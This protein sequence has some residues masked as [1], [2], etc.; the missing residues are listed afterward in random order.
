MNGRRLRV[1][2][3]TCLLGLGALISIA[4]LWPHAP[5]SR[6]A[7][8]ST[9]VYD[10]HG[11][12]LRLTLASDQQ[13]RLWTPLSAVSPDLVQALLLH[14]DQ[15]YRWH[16]G[17]NP[18]A[19]V[20]AAW[21]T[22]RG[23]PRQG[24]STITMQLAR[25][26]SHRDT[27]HVGGKLR[28]I[29]FALWLEARYSK[30]EIL[31]AYL[32]LLPLGRN[33]QGIGAASLIYFG[34]SADRL[35]LDEALTLALIPQSPR[36]R[37]PSSRETTSLQLA[38]SQFVQ[39][40][41]ADH[42]GEPAPMNTGLHYANLRQLPFE[43]PHLTDMLLNQAG[44]ATSIRSTIDLTLQHLM[45]RR[46]AEYVRA[47]QRVGVA[48][49]CALLVDTRTMAVKG[50]VGSANFFDGHIDGQ[51]NGVLAKRSPGSTLK[52]FIYALAIDQGLIHPY[53]MLKD[54]P[55]AFGSYSPENFDGAFEGPISAHDALIRSRNVPAV[56]L[57]ARLDQ[58]DLYEFLKAAGIS[59]LASEQHYG[60][61][62]A[63]GG[64]ETSME[65]LATLYA[66]LANGGVL[67]PLRYTV[68]APQ[69]AGPRLLS[70]EA[71]Y[72]VLSMLRDN[73]RPDGLASGA[74]F[75]AWK[76]GTSWGFRDA[77]SVGVVGPYVLAVWVGNFDGSSNPA[78]VGTQMAAPLFFNIA[79]GLAA[80]LRSLPG[81]YAHVPLGLRRVEVCAA[82]GDLPN[83]DCPLT[84]STWF[85]PG[86]SPIRVSTVHRRVE[87]DIRTGT[88]A[89]A[90]TPLQFRRNE[91]FEYWPSDLRLLFAQAGMPRRSPPENHCGPAFSAAAAPTITSPL[92]GTT[93]EFRMG[94]QGESSIAL[95][96]TTA[97]EVR[98]IY[99]FA[100]KAFLGASGPS[101]P[102]NWT[103]THDG[104]YSL[105]VVDDQG[106]S[107]T[108]PVRVAWA[109]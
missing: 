59:H 46:L 32:N 31:E 91:L 10:E 18:V 61:A 7:P 13:Y 108:R 9:A 56:A 5:L 93:Y 3:L 8:S 89:C 4:R 98:R 29:T 45:E 103:P 57:A 78:L 80:T 25:L 106:G 38:R 90:N 54:T 21:R 41:A 104:D 77:W 55:T 68:D 81:P 6:Y 23:E 16:Y 2:L 65:E 11:V 49:A 52:P 12:L 44:D 83:A 53:S 48:N 94:Q 69:T 100:D 73:P 105:T 30:D 22:A 84:T 79:D 87:I 60:L 24:A 96:A 50:M 37:E 35:T 101:M 85:I 33:I 58:P 26:I 43:A 97:P 74:T 76:S 102:L 14:E 17:V 88:Q 15:F 107:A 63:L 47:Q 51:V 71:S 36:A 19:L 42:P 109:P 92:S 72:M 67:H 70:P 40:W 95:N 28:Q 20:R 62:L 27:H 66:M 1:G 64:G 86:K 75:V 39:R 99:W 34:K 82:S